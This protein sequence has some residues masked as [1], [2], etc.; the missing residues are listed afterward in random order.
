MFR[1]RLDG[2]QEKPLPAQLGATL[3]QRRSLKLIG[4]ERSASVFRLVS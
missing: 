3:S 1:D 4:N 2:H